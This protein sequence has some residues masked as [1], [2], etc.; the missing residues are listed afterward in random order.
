VTKADLTSQTLRKLLDYDQET[1]VFTWKRLRRQG[2]ARVGDA[3]GAVNGAG[4]RQIGFALYGAKQCHRLAW[5]HVYGRWPVGEIDHING[6]KLDNRISNLRDVSR[7][8]NQQ[9]QRLPP[10]NNQSGF[11]G[12]C[13]DARQGFK[14]TLM[15]NKQ[16]IYLGSFKTPEEAYEA[17][18]K[19]KR[20]LHS[21]CT[22]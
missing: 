20:E 8:Q 1:G 18:L 15:N 9:N 10:R 22:I 12:V 19:A 3:A 11:L 6:D 5:L 2:R 13:K 16:S 17:Y 21:H 7:K 4:Y 14:A